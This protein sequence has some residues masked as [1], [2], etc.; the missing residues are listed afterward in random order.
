MLGLLATPRLLLTV[1]FAAT[2]CA[3]AGTV[4]WQHGRIEQL[5]EK[6][7]AE[8]AIVSALNATI[9]EQNAAVVELAEDGRRR[10]QR[11]ARAVKTAPVAR[12][13]VVDALRGDPVGDT[14]AARVEDIDRRLL[15]SLR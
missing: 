11:A 15:E 7:G 9:A 14:P 6:L 1:G 8:R 5:N 4:V 2:V 10:Q 13:K 12:E 3:L